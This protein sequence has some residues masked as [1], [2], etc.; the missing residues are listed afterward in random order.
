VL[1]AAKRILAVGADTKNRFCLTQGKRI[2]L[3]PDLGDLSLAD[4]YERLKKAISLALKK[5]KGQPQVV[6]CDRHPGY[7]STRLAIQCAQEINAKILYVQHHQ[8]HIASVLQEHSLNRPVIGV[9]FDGTGFGLDGQIWG[10]EFLLVSGKSLERLAHFRNL[11]MPGAEQVIHEPWRMVLS[12]LGGKA[13]EWLSNIPKDRQRIVMAMITKGINAPLTSSVGRLFDA[14][15][16]LL[17][18]CQRSGYEAEGPIKLSAL[19]E[20]RITGNYD[21]EI[22]T[23]KGILIIDPTAVFMAM[24]RELKRGQS[25]TVIATRFHNTMTQITIETLKRLVKSTGVT[26][27]VYSGGV[28][29]NQFLTRQL[30]RALNKK[31]YRVY[32]NEKNPVNDLNISLGQYYVSR[33]SSKN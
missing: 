26:D 7:L 29:Q 28:F 2:Y 8:A 4:N 17:G 25:Q 15:A 14:A 12:I 10:G 24:A 11:A 20:E 27:I 1:K 32:S 5:Q 9:A 23:T 16:A 19:C 3:G 31:R 6:A 33:Y 22:M 21:F 18:I 30:R 13:E